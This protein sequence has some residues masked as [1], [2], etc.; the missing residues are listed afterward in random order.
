M[1][2]K[3][4]S[5]YY[6]LNLSINSELTPQS[7][8]FTCLLDYSIWIWPQTEFL[9]FLSQL[10]FS[11][12]PLFPQ[13]LRLKIWVIFTSFLSLASHSQSSNTTCFLLQCLPGPSLPYSFYNLIWTNVMTLCSAL[14]AS[15]LFFPPVTVNTTKWIPPKYSF[16]NHTS[17]LKK[18]PWLSMAYWM[19][20]E[21]F[22]LLFKASTM[23]PE[24]LFLISF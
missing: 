10:R 23:W 21:F 15:G 12:W 1:S 22:H 11:S 6:L 5:I 2:V 16:D 7:C 18:L 20:S 3:A 14:P 4:V 24:V 17:Q 19:K 9:N 13:L 8:I